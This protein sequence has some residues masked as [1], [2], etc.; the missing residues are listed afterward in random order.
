MKAFALDSEHRAIEPIDITDHADLAR[1]IGYDTI[2]PNAVGSADDQLF[3]DEECF[4]CGT[5]GRFQIDSAIPVPGKAELVGA[6]DEGKPLR[7]VI[8]DVDSRC[9]RIGYL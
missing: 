9:S 5:K 8:T 1:L 2:E 3:F 4:L 6:A 7:N